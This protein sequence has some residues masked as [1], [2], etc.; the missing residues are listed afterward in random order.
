[1]S[2][3]PYRL[4]HSDAVISKATINARTRYS[5]S[6]HVA[7]SNFSFKIAAKPLQVTIDSLRRPILNGTIADALRRRLRFRHVT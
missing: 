6:A 4:R 2:K 5:N 1:M 3:V 7:G